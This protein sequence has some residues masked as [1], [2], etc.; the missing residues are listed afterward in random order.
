MSDNL[1]YVYKHPYVNMVRAYKHPYKYSLLKPRLSPPRTGIPEYL[2]AAT[3]DISGILSTIK[4]D[5]I[6]IDYETNHTQYYRDDFKVVG[7]GLTWEGGRLYLANTDT[8]LFFRMN[9]LI[10]RLKGLI[11]HNMYFDAG[12]YQVLTGEQLKFSY[13]TYGLYR[14]LANEG[15]HG[16][17]WGLKDAQIDM[18]LWTETNEVELDKWLITNGHFTTQKGGVKKSNKSKMYLAPPQILGKYCILDTESTYLLFKHIL[19]PVICTE[20]IQVDTYHQ[21]IF[22][23]LLNQLIFQFI[24]GIKVDVKLLNKHRDNLILHIA[25]AENTLRSEPL[26]NKYLETEAQSR[27]NAI[28]IPRQHK[29]IKLGEE[30]SKFNKKGQINK[31]WINWDIKRQKSENPEVTTAWTNYLTKL[32]DLTPNSLSINSNKI[33]KHIVYQLYYPRHYITQEGVKLT[34]SHY[35]LPLTATGGL[36]TGKAALKSMGQIGKLYLTYKKLVKE[37]S[38]VESYLNLV[39]H[40]RI[41]PGF[42]VPGTLTGR[43]AGS[44]PN[45]QQLSK[46]GG[47]L[48]SFIPDEGCIWVDVDHTSL[49]NVVLAELSQDAG[50]DFLYGE[51]SMDNDSYL[52]VG[53]NLP[54][55]GDKIR[56]CGYDP[57][58]PTFEAI[59]KAKKE[60][61]KERD[62]A[63]IIVLSCN[64]GAGIKK[65]HQTLKLG[66]IDI[67]LEECQKIYDGYWKLFKQVKAYENTLKREVEDKGYVLSPLDQPICCSPDKIKD[68]LNSMCQKTGHDI[69]M[70]W[71]QIFTTLL[72]RA[73]IEW[74]PI[75]IDWHDQSIIQVRHT[76]AETTLE[77][78]KNRAFFELNK[79]LSTFGW[80]TTMKGDGGIVRNLAEAKLGVDWN[81]EKKN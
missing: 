6:A 60:C 4:S 57:Y 2:Y 69:H 75:V 58:K 50:L 71:V 22:I 66:G 42:R 56:T 51:D 52:F 24:N 12:V 20:H 76:D 10:G 14:Q 65:I 13:C 17:R 46:S 3:V 29:Y 25:E 81:V 15:H 21:Q 80:N 47:F 23:P 63:K 5:Y 67:T 55:I 30:P 16:Q 73:G 28:K 27:R 48:Q 40:D 9:L 36:P 26:I 32:S 45:I 34:S 79:Q 39:Y 54:I 70:I 61:K 7:V 43:L 11:G 49:E 8:Q 1:S 77:I 78:M 38:M 62:I 44:K 53:A 19:L 18:L 59:L 74:S 35:P 72:D 33:M 41:H 64:Y 68:I 31:T 37:L